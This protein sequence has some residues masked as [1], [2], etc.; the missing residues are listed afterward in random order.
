M[1]NITYGAN[2]TANKRLK[3]FTS[4]FSFIK[5]LKRFDNRLSHVVWYST[6]ESVDQSWLIVGKVYTF[7]C[8]GRWEV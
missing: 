7:H 3:R 4:L 8:K 1:R 6:S 2:N 5:V